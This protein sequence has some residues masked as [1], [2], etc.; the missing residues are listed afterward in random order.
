ML[1]PQPAVLCPAPD[2]L[3]GYDSWAGRGGLPA[4]TRRATPVLLLRGG[5]GAWQCRGEEG[6]WIPQQGVSLSSAG[7]EAGLGCQV[8][9]LALTTSLLVLLLPLHLGLALLAGRRPRPV[10]V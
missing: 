7:R 4:R 6:R 1:A 3:V 9:H 2:W 8:F 5:A 10:W